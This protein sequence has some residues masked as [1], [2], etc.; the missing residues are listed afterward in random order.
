LVPR[1]YKCLE[2]GEGILGDLE[3]LLERFEDLGGKRKELLGQ[4][5]RHR[6]IE[7]RWKIDPVNIS[8]I[9][10]IPNGRSA[11]NKITYSSQVTMKNGDKI[12]IPDVNIKKFLDEGEEQ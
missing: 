1:S 5:I 2:W 4:L 9:R 11:I 8:A 12:F 10:L 6:Q 7:E 3:E